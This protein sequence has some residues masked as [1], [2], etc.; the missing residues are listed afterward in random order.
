MARTT[1]L[2]VAQAQD[3][4]QIAGATRGRGERMRLAGQCKPLTSEPR[5]VTWRSEGFISADEEGVPAHVRNAYVTA[6]AEAAAR[7]SAAEVSK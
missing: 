2:T 7:N 5:E 1:K 4:G 6:F 3:L